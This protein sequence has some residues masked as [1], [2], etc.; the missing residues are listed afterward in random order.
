QQCAYVASVDVS[1]SHN[2]DAVIAQLVDVEVVA[3]DAA[4]QRSNER[5]DFRGRQHFIEAR[6]LDIQDLALERQDG[7]RAPIAA[8]LRR[9]AGGV[10]FHQEHF[11]ERG[12]LLL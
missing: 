8:L 1:I 9:A 12:I 11:R 4:A 10:A 3:S 5:P 6:L 2:Y 7:L